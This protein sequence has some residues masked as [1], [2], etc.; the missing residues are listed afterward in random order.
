MKFDNLSD[1]D[2]EKLKQFRESYGITSEVSTIEYLNSIAKDPEVDKLIDDYY[3]LQ[4]EC[5]KK[6]SPF[7]VDFGNIIDEFK[8]FVDQYK[9][10]NI[11]KV[12]DD[13]GNNDMNDYVEILNIVKNKNIYIPL[14]VLN[15]HIK[16]TKDQIKSDKENIMDFADD[17]ND[18]YED[19]KNKG[20]CAD[21]EIAEI[22]IQEEILKALEKRKK[23][24]EEKEPASKRRSTKRSV[25]RSTKRSVKRRST[26]R[27]STKRRS[28]KRST[29]RSAKVEGCIK[30]SSKKYMSRPSPPYPAQECKEQEKMGN[31]GQLYKSVMKANGI[32]AWKKMK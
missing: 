7:R 19:I 4:D 18:T 13:L 16:Y 9:Y 21:T 5:R 8:N 24:I 32:Y 2:I 6:E 11:G 28:T 3:A 10:K 31:D 26:K 22:E 15:R 25:K 14:D 23:E 27:R 12:L 20:D 17:E 30:Q 1:K 29:K